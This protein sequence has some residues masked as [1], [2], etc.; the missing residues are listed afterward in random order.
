MIPQNEA[1]IV[2]VRANADVIYATKA[3]AVE[4]RPRSVAFVIFIDAVP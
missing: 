1:G 4:S 2:G 3:G